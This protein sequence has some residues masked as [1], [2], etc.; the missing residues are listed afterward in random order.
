MQ[1]ITMTAQSLISEETQEGC[2]WGAQLL[3]DINA[4][5]AQLVP[6]SSYLCLVSRQLVGMSLYI[7]VSHTAHTFVAAA[8]SASLPLGA[9]RVMGNKGA[10]E[11]RL[12]IGPFA[13]QFINC[14][15]APHPPNVEQRNQQVSSLISP[16]HCIVA[17]SPHR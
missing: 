7:F 14:H 4:C 10:V 9:L 15:L 16:C 13:L 1:E 17:Q 6:P 12:L 8:S 11:A 3:R 2:D 5:A